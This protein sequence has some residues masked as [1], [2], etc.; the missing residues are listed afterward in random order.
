MRYL[1]TLILAMQLLSCSIPTP[2]LERIKQDGELVVITRNSA[3]TYFEGREGTAGIEYDL[4]RMFARELGV[5]VRFITPDSFDQIIPMIKRREA[6]FA[7]AG[8][9]VTKE[10]K[11][12]V[13]FAPGYQQITQQ[14]IFRNGEK[15]PKSLRDV[16]GSKFEVI[17]GS[18]HE[19]ELERHK[20]D[21]P[22]LEWIARRELESEELL[23]MV[24][25][26]EIDYTIGDSNEV[27]LNRRFYPELLVAFNLTPPEQ[28][29]WAFPHEE[30][31]SLFDAAADFIRRTKKSGKLEQLIER[32]Y[33]YVKRLGFVDTNTFKQ[34]VLI[35][36]PKYIS[37]F[38]ESAKTTGITWELLAA[39]G[40]QE[41]H[42]NPDAVSPTGVRGIMML[43]E[44]TAEQMDIPD[45]TVPK[46]SIEGG[47]KYLLLLSQK[48]PPS[49]V[50]PDRMWFTLAAYNVGFGHLEDA[51]ILTQRAGKN[52]DKWQD[53]KQYLPLLSRKAYYQT[54]KHGYAR[55]RE[56]VD[57]VDN[58]RGYHDLLT[59]LIDQST[60]DEQSPPDIFSS[61]VL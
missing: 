36:L 58:I 1:L 13:K 24:H 30:D 15:Q 29:A 10:R 22:E 37:Y 53:V 12:E 27:A 16:I 55:G 21:I 38:K 17:A 61:S 32:Y 20:K 59:W 23:Y 9:T 41:S 45:R 60:E 44:A 42:W 31:S 40:Y 26:G 33:G 48:I 28:L 11:V 46:Q 52:P 25:T 4:V 18:S 3:T 50:P 6:H 54:V 7:A 51:R 2:L 35:R 47:A 8:L 5:R 57:Y 39:I 34:H 43:T 49:V 56:P 19:A 14:L